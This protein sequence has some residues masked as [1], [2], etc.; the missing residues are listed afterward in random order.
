MLRSQPS[1][2]LHTSVRCA[3][4]PA[5]LGMLG[6]VPHTVGKYRLQF[7]GNC[8]L[9]GVSE[10]WCRSKLSERKISPLSAF[11]SRCCVLF[12]FSFDCGTVKYMKPVIEEQVIYLEMS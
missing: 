11:H 10:V 3:A 4:A 6:G 5:V 9:P 7:D 2:G 8:F 1:P 12:L